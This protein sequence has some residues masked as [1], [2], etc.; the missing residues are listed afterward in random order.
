MLL[1][2]LSSGNANNSI[3]KEKILNVFLN[4]EDKKGFEDLLKQYKLTS[5]NIG[6]KIQTGKDQFGSQV[7][8]QVI[9]FQLDEKAMF[10]S[11][12]KIA[13]KLASYDDKNLCIYMTNIDNKYKLLI[14]QLIAKHT[15]S[16]N[17]YKT[18]KSD[19]TS[20]EH[21]YIKDDAKNKSFIEDII[22]QINIANVNRDFQNEP[23]NK[24]YPETFCTYAK[25]ILGK[26]AH[27]KIKVLDD[28]ELK[29]QG[30]NLIYEMGKASIN[31]PRFMIVNYIQNPKYKTICLIGKGV[32]FDLGGANMKPSTNDLFEMK[33][34]NLGSCTLVSLIK[35]VIESGMKINIIGLMPMIQNLISGNLVLPGDIVKSYSGKSVE[36]LNSNAEGRL[37]LADAFDYSNTLDNID[38]I[39]DISTL[40][41]SAS[42]FH[43]DTVCAFFTINKT[44][45]NY[46]EEISETVG[47]RVYQIPP[48]LEY[49]ELTKSDVANVQNNDSTNCPKSGTFMGALFIANFVPK[50]LIDKW[51]HVDVTH[52]YTGH[53]SNGNTTI[54]LINLLK[55]LS[56]T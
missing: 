24:I 31:K 13:T 29:K 33:T 20:V 14:L 10:Y 41:G 48:W 39:F 5:E 46:I 9:F 16:F 37:C 38:Y 42:Y 50:K 30:F 23:A 21:I 52:N 8:T 1:H 43:C 36:I 32:C 51:I 35:Y 34:D 2:F 26:H 12:K 17:K 7:G 54:L 19:S 4:V 28:K 56:S 45:K 22:H 15:Y 53:L 18:S 40:T 49:M 3:K 47:E 55:R 6:N 44:I 27:L 11:T 25:K